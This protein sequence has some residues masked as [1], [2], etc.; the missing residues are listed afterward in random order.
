MPAGGEAS[1]IYANQKYDASIYSANSENRESGGIIIA[2]F[3][4]PECP[5]AKAAV[6]SGRKRAADDDGRNGK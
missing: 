3:H 6:M 5:P 1:R 2:V 4:L